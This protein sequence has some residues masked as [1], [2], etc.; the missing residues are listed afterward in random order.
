MSADTI[1]CFENS[2]YFYTGYDEERGKH[3]FEMPNPN[4]SMFSLAT[5]EAVGMSFNTLLIQYEEYEVTSY[6][7]SDGNSYYIELPNPDYLS[8]IY[9]ENVEVIF[10]SDNDLDLSS[11]VPLFGAMMGVCDEPNDT[12]RLIRT[13]PVG[14]MKYLNC[15]AAQFGDYEIEDVKYYGV[16]SAT[17]NYTGIYHFIP[18]TTM[19]TLPE[20]SIIRLGYELCAGESYYTITVNDANSYFYFYLYPYLRSDAELYNTAVIKNINDEVSSIDD[21]TK[22]IDQTN[23]SILEKIKELPATLWAKFEEGL[24][25]LFIPEDGWLEA[26]FDKLK[27]NLEDALGFLAFPFV[28]VEEFLSLFNQASD[29]TDFSFTLPKLEFMGHTVWEEYTFSI[30]ESYSELA[31]MGTL[32]E[33]LHLFCKFVIIIALCRLGAKKFNLILTGVPDN[34]S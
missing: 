5:S 22:S 9:I 4:M 19:T 23:K 25:A 3:C 15:Y 32:F 29:L 31:F 12:V 16:Q 11:T 6:F 2:G 18:D 33:V 1:E 26:E 20:D 10:N 24:K 7:E 27:T 13:A 34:D 14:N 30:E 28:L 21:T 17:N 8:V